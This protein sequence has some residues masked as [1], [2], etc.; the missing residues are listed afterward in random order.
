MKAKSSLRDFEKRLKEL[1]DEE[2]SFFF[3]TPFNFSGKPFCGTFDGTS[4]NLTRNSFWRHIKSISIKGNYKRLGTSTEIEYTIDVS[5]FTRIFSIIF[6]ILTLVGINIFF[7]FKRQ[8]FD[9][10]AVIGLNIFWL[11]GAVI[12]IV[13]TW[14][15]KK[16]VKERFHTEFDIED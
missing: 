1:T 12:A 5:R 8:Q 3:L 16:I 11:F 10:T 9:T 15:G 4:F 14:I 7:F 6:Y 2:S 13:V